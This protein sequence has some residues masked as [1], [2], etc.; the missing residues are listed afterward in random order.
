MFFPETLRANVVTGLG[1]ITPGFFAVLDCIKQIHPEL[2]CGGFEALS[3]E[4]EDGWFK[5]CPIHLQRRPIRQGR[6]PPCLR[7]RQCRY[8]NGIGN[9]HRSPSPHPS[10]P[11]RHL[12]RRV[13]YHRESSFPGRVHGVIV[14]RGRLQ[15]NVGWWYVGNQSHGSSE[16]P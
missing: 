14:A 7:R 8:R 4:G 6:I 15:D 9:R 2:L 16:Y 13:S 1:G 10:S 12:P 11:S 5:G 3:V